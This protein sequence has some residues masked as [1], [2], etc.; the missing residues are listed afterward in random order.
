MNNLIHQ[1]LFYIFFIYGISFLVMAR[2]VF[3]GV[4]QATSISL[5]TSYYALALFGLTHGIT[6]VVDWLRFIVKTVGT[7]EIRA[8]TYVSQCL[9]V[10]SFVL[11]LQFGVNLLTYRSEKGRPL[12][13]APSILFVVYL[14]A[15]AFMKVSDITQAGLIARYTFG[16]AG[17][18][19]SGIALF[20]LAKTMQEVVDAAVI[21]GLVVTAVG[22]CAYAVFGGL[23]IT[24]LLG[25]PIQLFRAGCAFTIAVASFYIL[26]V[27]KAD[28]TAAE[29][30]EAVELA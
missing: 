19:L 27:F 8:L 18:L 15:L 16:F 13:M 28:Q 1:P 10:V 26:G 22:F 2:V 20:T 24:P 3:H 7:P 11:L 12:R 29:P 30:A 17:A 9:L 14:A 4:R 5:V 21:Q 25:M 6:E 23:V